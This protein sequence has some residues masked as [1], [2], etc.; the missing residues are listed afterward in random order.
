MKAELRLWRFGIGLLGGP[1]MLAMALAALVASYVA[2]IEVMLHPLRQFDGMA[3]FVT[4]ATIYAAAVFL[5]AIL[6]VT[7]IWR[8][9]RDNTLLRLTPNVSALIRALTRRICMVIP[10]ALLPAVFLRA[11]STLKFTHGLNSVVYLADVPTSA[12]VMASLYL[13]HIA[14]LLMLTFG[15]F[16]VPPRFAFLPIFYGAV[17][18]SSGGFFWIPLIACVVIII[19]YYLWRRLEMGSVL[20]PRRTS[21][22]PVNLMT[23]WDAWQLRR[24]ANAS[25]RGQAYTRAAALLAPREHWA[26]FA[27]AVGAVTSYVFLTI[28]FGPR[29]EGPLLMIYM[30]AAVVVMPT[31]IPLA[32]IML[33]PIGGE[34]DGV[35]QIIARVWLRAAMTRLMLAM[36]VAM[37]VNAICWWLEWPAFKFISGAARIDAE[38]QLLWR[39]L[40]QALAL[41]GIVTAMCLLISASPHPLTKRARLEALPVV[42]LAGFSV[43]GGGLWWLVGPARPGLDRAE[44]DILGFVVFNGVALPTIAWL[45]HR[46]LRGQWRR[47]NLGMIAQAMQAWSARMDAMWKVRK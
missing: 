28:L 5:G 45:I 10:I 23:M 3:Q 8:Q 42:L 29:Y 44:S 12:M 15:L 11:L 30:I 37:T 47:A 7:M 24:A 22:W 43:I 18:W 16:R 19:G 46:A 2:L 34:R 17:T 38:T 14:V 20:P 35:G 26:K 9:Q 13:V 27:L 21:P 1:W 32:R 39:P 4:Q 25:G 33:L 40:A 36:V 6:A 41:G 31:P